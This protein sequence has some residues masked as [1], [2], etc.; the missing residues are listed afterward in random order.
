MNY[1]LYA[2]C[3]RTDCHRS[4]ATRKYWSD[5]QTQQNNKEGTDSVKALPLSSSITSQLKYQTIEYGLDTPIN[6]EMLCNSSISSSTCYHCLRAMID[7]F[8]A[9]KLTQCSNNIAHHLKSFQYTSINA[10]NLYNQPVDA[11]PRSTSTGVANI[12]GSLQNCAQLTTNQQCPCLCS[13]HAFDICLCTPTSQCLS[14]SFAQICATNDAKICYILQLVNELQLAVNKVNVQVRNLTIQTIATQLTRTMNG[15]EMVSCKSAKDRT[16]MATTWQTIRQLHAMGVPQHQALQ[17]LEHLRSVGVRRG[18][19][20][21]NTGK[22]NYAF[23]GIQRSFLPDVLKPHAST[24][25]GKN[26]S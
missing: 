5:Q 7:T 21:K 10:V 4:Q 14:C 20:V 15:G 2:S 3:G 13:C 24:C 1:W 9:V 8:S 11:P 6:I 19:V 18:N 12:S 22:T 17:L 26:V 25:S 23:S 16:S